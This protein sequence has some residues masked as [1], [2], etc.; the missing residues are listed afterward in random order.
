MQEKRKN[1]NEEVI[2]NHDCIILAKNGKIVPVI[3]SCSPVKDEKG[4]ILGTVFIARD[5]TE[6]KQVEER[7]RESNV[8]YQ[9]IFESTGT[10][11]FIIDED[12]TILMANNECYSTLGYTA[13]EIIGQK[14]SQYVAP[15]SLQETLKNHQ[16]RR[17]NPDLTPIKYEIKVVTKKGEILSV[18]LNVGMIPFTKQSIVSFSDITELKRAEKAL[19]QS[20]KN[21]H[22]SISESPLGICIVSVDGKSIYANK[23]FLDIFE[24][25]SLEEFKSTPAINRYIPE[26]YAQHQEIKEK[27]EKGNDVFDY[28]ISIILKTTEIRY[29]KVLRKEIMWN[30]IK[31]YQ[32]IN[33]DITEQK[34]LTLDL[35][36]A[37]ERAEE[38]D[39]LKSAFL[40]NMSHE[41]RTPMNGILGFTE[42]LKEPGLT[43][44]KQQEYISIIHK[45]G[46]R[47]LNIINDIIDISK[48]ESGQMKVSLEETNV[49]VQIEFIYKFFK[50]EAERKGLYLFL[51]T[52]LSLSESTII[53]DREKLYAILTNLV[54]NAIKYTN[55]GSIEF[56]CGIVETSHTTSL[57]FYVKDTGIGIP[58]H[59][60]EAIFERFIQAD[61]TK[62]RAYQGAGLGLTIS[63]AYV[64]MLGGKIWVE[65]EEGIGSTFYFTLPI[66]EKPDEK[67]II[68]NEIPTSVGEPRMNKLKILL[69]EDDETSEIL[70]SITINEFSKTIIV[71][72]NGNEAVEICR[73]NPDIDLIL[74]D[75]QIPEI[76]GYE[77]TRQI[78]QFNKEVVIIA[79]TAFAL[80]GDREESIDAGCNDYIAK[81]IKKEE[82]LSLIQK[83]FK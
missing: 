53:T 65:S 73:N 36:E 35:I 13:T 20:E 45:S 41:I 6:P 27:R 54:N 63:K 3:Y 82:L 64:E 16:L 30:G 22:R 25:N 72:R 37:K 33:Q 12:T 4:I 40:A 5:I 71:A 23:A 8:K 51:K 56:G 11:I 78:R 47:M 26:S 31:H 1:A 57:Q 9:T 59:R 39:R 17:N 83:Y 49:K 62:K 67:K 76:D 46:N 24:F 7:L 80:S 68:K 74:M 2:T 48:I 70:I 38:S 69:V 79:Q 43:S 21:F 34:K 52:N 66:M 58:K 50:A 77:A 81:P 44:E 14:W 18:I 42:V 75:I 61:I 10:A 28:E 60:Q 55:S 32:I 19:L 29:I 15:E